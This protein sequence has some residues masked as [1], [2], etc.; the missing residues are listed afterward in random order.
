[1]QFSQVI[2]HTIMWL[3]YCSRKTVLPLEVG[4]HVPDTSRLLH[5][6]PH[7]TPQFSFPPAAEPGFFSLSLTK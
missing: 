1:M 5:D 7:G 3:A 4:L 6:L 2:A